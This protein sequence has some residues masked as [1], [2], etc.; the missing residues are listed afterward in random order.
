[1][2]AMGRTIAQCAKESENYTVV[3][4]FDREA[5]TSL[6]FPVFTDYDN[7]DVE[8]DVIIDFSNPKNLAGL[9]GY[10]KANSKPVVVATT[11]FSEEQICDIHDAAAFA[12]IFFSANMSLGISLLKELAMTAA[13]V[14]GD[15]FD[16]E[17]VERHH[18]KKV[19]AP[20]GTALLLANAVSS[21]LPYDSKYTYDRHST[22]EKRQKKEIGMHSVRG[23]TIVGDHD[24]IFAGQDEIITLS[25]NAH[26]KAVFAQGALSAA[27]FL[28]KCEKGM[29]D[30]ADLVQSV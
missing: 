25:H 29:Y 16:I 9:L 8:Y 4:G 24:I 19:D 26:S 14:L 12:P 23:G 6:G 30:M 1:M 7:I 5:D 11:G 2:G 22:R 3:A 17:I 13:K 28:A 18:N 20:S 15:S 10:V 21:A 27:A